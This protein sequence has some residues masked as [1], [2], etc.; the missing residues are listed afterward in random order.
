MALALASVVISA[1]FMTCIFGI[2]VWNRAENQIEVQQ[3]LRIAMNTLSTEVRKAISFEIEPKGQGIILTYEGEPK[4]TYRFDEPSG[5]I[6]MYA[7]GTT[8]AMHI[9]DCRFSCVGDLITIEIITEAMEGLRERIYAFS[10]N[11]RGKNRD[12]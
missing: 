5:E 12:G 8:V 9:K 10:L 7:K 11:T 2:K 1:V 3:N 4:K 6:R